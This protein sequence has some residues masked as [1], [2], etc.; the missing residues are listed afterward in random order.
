MQ[1]PVDSTVTADDLKSKGAN[2]SAA[3]EFGQFFRNIPISA[4]EVL[5]RYHDDIVA[6]L[7]IKMKIDV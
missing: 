7:N 4:Q 6:S 2:A 3:K 1:Y 5:I